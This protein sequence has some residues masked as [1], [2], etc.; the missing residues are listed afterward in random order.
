ML[1]RECCERFRNWRTVH[2]VLDL[3]ES[4][5]KDTSGPDAEG[6]KH[7]WTWANWGDVPGTPKGRPACRLRT[8]RTARTALAA[9]RI[10]LPPGQ[11]LPIE[12]ARAPRVEVPNCNSWEF[13]T[14]QLCQQICW[15][16][17]T[18][19]RGTP[20]VIVQTHRVLLLGHPIRQRLSCTAA[21][22]EEEVPDTV[23]LRGRRWGRGSA[24]Q[25][26]DRGSTLRQAGQN[27]ACDQQVFMRLFFR[28]TF[29]APSLV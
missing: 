21:Q 14:C 7:A 11:V 13:R 15:R 6:C 8:A 3:S 26:A 1:Q 22:L 16:P 23:G 9:R 17:L 25:P 12:V 24:W 10:V 4:G 2:Q 19:G 18:D 29:D 27:V 28:R 20:K 5:G